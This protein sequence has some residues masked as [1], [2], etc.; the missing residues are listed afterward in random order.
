[1][2]LYIVLPLDST[3]AD[4]CDAQSCSCFSRQCG[5]QSNLSG[6]YNDLSLCAGS[7]HKIVEHSR[8]KPELIF[9]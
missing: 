5:R 1:M 8:R 3:Q 7:V 4:Q 9:E 2:Y 6:L